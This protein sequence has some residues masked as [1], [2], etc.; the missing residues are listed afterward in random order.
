MS[1]YT[2][3][4]SEIYVEDKD[5]VQFAPE[6]ASNLY[7]LMV[8]DSSARLGFKIA[9]CSACQGEPV[10]LSNDDLDLT[11][12]MDLHTIEHAWFE[13]YAP[14]TQSDFEKVHDLFVA[15][16]TEEMQAFEAARQIRFEDGLK[17]I[18]SVQDGDN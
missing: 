1:S 7:G 10:D 2:K 14:T 4:G 8:A 16:L 12:S 3:S 11:I 17:H 5:T 18:A 6:T 13:K 9:L 15:S